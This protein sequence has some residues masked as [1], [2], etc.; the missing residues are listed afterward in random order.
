MKIY[1]LVLV[2]MLAIAEEAPATV[3]LFDTKLNP[4]QRANACFELRGK[5]DAETV[6]A[7]ARAMED[8]EMLACAAENLRLAG[9]IDPLKQALASSSAE[10]RATAA[11]VLG[12]FQRPDLLESLNRAAQDENALVAT[13]ALAGLSRYQDASVIP[14]LGAIAR[15]GGMTGDMALERLAQMDADGALKIARELLVSTQVP[16]QLYAMRVIGQ[17]GNASDV[18]ALK[19]I[20]GSSSENL[21]QRGRGFGLMPPINLARAAQGAIEEIEKRH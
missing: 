2:P 9:A 12:S 10:V 4:T 1:M 6:G 13:N 3:R 19:K 18:P 11:R 15:K 20:A 21:A 17:A 16:D 7:L 14:Y 5:S 8:P